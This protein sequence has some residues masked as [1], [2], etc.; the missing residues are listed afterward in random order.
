MYQAYTKERVATQAAGGQQGVAQVSKPAVS[1]IS[2]SAA[3]LASGRARVCESATPQTRRCAR[4]G[5]AQ[6]R[7]FIPQWAPAFL[8]FSALLTAT[9][10]V[11]AQNVFNS[12]GQ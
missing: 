6:S 4:P 3:P 8:I 9:G 10:A 2:K 7:S 1:P 5:G 12:Q 11:Q